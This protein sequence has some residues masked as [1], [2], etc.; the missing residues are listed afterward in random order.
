MERDL[1]KL[2][3]IVGC[4]LFL[5][6]CADILF[7][8]KAPGIS[9][10]VFSILLLGAT[11]MLTRRFQ[12]T[13]DLEAKVLML[14]I[15]ALSS[16]VF[17]RSSILIVA[18]D[19]TASLC[20]YIFLLGRFVGL[21][22]REFSVLHY[23]RQFIGAPAQ[24]L[25][26]SFWVLKDV[27]NSRDEL[28]KNVTLRQAGRGIMLTIPIFAVLTLLLSSA[29]L[30][31]NKYVNNSVEALK[32][33]NFFEH[34]S[35]VVTAFIILLGLLTYAFCR[36]SKQK[37]GEEMELAITRK[38]LGFGFSKSFLLLIGINSIVFIFSLFLTVL[39]ASFYHVTAPLSVR[40]MVPLLPPIALSLV[41]AYA[42]SFYELQE[43]DEHAGSM[44]AARS[45]TISFV[46]S[47]IILGSVD[48]LLIV[49]ILL[50]FTYLFGGAHNITAQG[51]T[52]AEYAHKGFF[53][54]IAV[55]LLSFA[56]IWSTDSRTK[57]V[58][59]SQTRWL[60]ILNGV[61]ISLVS[62]IMISAFKRLLI[63]EAAYGYTTLRVYTQ[64]FIVLVG[65]ISL[66]LLYKLATDRSEVWFCLR[67][68]TVVILFLIGMN[69]ANIDGIIAK[70]NIE[71]FKTSHDKKLLVFNMDLSA[72][73]IDQAIESY[74]LLDPKDRSSVINERFRSRLNSIQE[75]SWQSY[76]LSNIHA[77]EKL[78]DWE[79]DH[80]RISSEGR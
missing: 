26:E 68:F 13:I 19:I 41:F 52:Y 65:V 28:V 60:K 22:L 25:V 63:Y 78:N 11:L 44:V 40:I 16:M 48:A 47:S 7:Y 30:V 77:L 20:L 2:S 39:F 14:L 23:L 37:Q 38:L 54:L 75:L 4:A 31:F 21:S 15:L 76:S 24:S 57:L 32:R 55:A 69:V 50:Q 36:L 71:Q 9:V 33:F 46:E 73:A 35:I 70:L 53:E 59:L 12:A 43:A 29:D 72:D 42:F 8:R 67:S 58:N 56:I 10:V 5:A 45:G 17:V 66:L 49:F 6:V 34:I 64:I 79:V 1:S 51:F 18:L 61:L 80:A 27:V 74:N 62:L 3:W